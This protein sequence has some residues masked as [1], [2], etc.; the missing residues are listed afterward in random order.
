MRDLFTFFV[1]RD[2]NLSPLDL[3]FAPLVTLMSLIQ[4]YVSTKLYV[5]TTS[6]FGENRGH[7]TKGQTDRRT[8]GRTECDT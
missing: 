1:P 3:K 2:P 5:S 4:C 7:G 6:V 8:D